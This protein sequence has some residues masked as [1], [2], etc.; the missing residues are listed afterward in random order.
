MRRVIVT[1]ALALGWLAVPT[2]AYSCACAAASPRPP[3]ADEVRRNVRDRLDRARAAFIGEVVASN[4]LTYRFS[5]ES[6]WKGDLGPEVVMASGAEALSNGLIGN[7]SCSYSFRTGQRYLVFAFGESHLQ[8]RAYECDLTTTAPL[9]Q[10]TIN[11]L[12]AIQPRREPSTSIAADR[13]VAVIGNVNRPG[14][15]PWRPGMT[16]ADA[17]EAAGGVVPQVPDYAT[18]ARSTVTRGS[19]P[20][21]QEEAL[22]STPLQPDDQLSVVGPLIKRND[23]A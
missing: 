22:P 7:S 15:I 20:N 3:S 9:G 8:M 1:V 10:A 5:V 17:I 14:L 13:V 6:V 4:Q 16:V 2:D 19:S 11:V 18:E 21:K 23:D 12:D